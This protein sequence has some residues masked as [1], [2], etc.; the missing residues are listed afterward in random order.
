MKTGG[1][2]LILDESTDVDSNDDTISSLNN[3]SIFHKDDFIL[4]KLLTLATRY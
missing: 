3:S 1:K 2:I 4:C